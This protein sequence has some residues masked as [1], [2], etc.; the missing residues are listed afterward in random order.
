MKSL[1]IEEE[2]NAVKVNKDPFVQ[3]LNK[4]VARKKAPAF[5]SA[6]ILKN[7]VDAAE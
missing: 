1:I 2:F 6:L 5:L 7:T 4:H 3:F